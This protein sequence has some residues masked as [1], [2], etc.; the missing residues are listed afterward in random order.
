MCWIAES[1][2]VGGCPY[3]LR[4]TAFRQL[5]A[6]GGTLGRSTVACCV[7]TAH[8]T[9]CSNAL[10][11]SSKPLGHRCFVCEVRRL[12]LLD[13]S[14]CP[15][16][17][18]TEGMLGLRCD[19]ALSVNA[20]GV[21][22]WLWSSLRYRPSDTA[23]SLAVGLRGKMQWG[24]WFSRVFREAA[25]EVGSM[26]TAGRVAGHHHNV[27]FPK[28]VYILIAPVETPTRWLIFLQRAL[29]FIRLLNSAAFKITLHVRT[30][31][32]DCKSN[33]TLPSV[34]SG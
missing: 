29:M 26:L 22:S 10:Q 16:W 8:N 32:H 5:V 31:I 23:A 18:H 9:D 2:F 1:P 7:F 13:V 33:Q 15:P 20:E 11:T 30:V 17:G 25:A 34:P 12:Q 6:K 28:N 24:Q 3:L 14:R 21:Q 27:W 4:S 19:S